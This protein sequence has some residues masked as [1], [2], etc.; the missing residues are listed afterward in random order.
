MAVL[1][2]DVRTESFNKPPPP[3]KKWIQDYLEKDCKREAEKS[4]SRQNLGGVVQDVIDH[5]QDYMDESN[6]RLG[7]STVQLGIGR[8]EQEKSNHFNQLLDPAMYGDK[9]NRSLEKLQQTSL[10]QSPVPNLSRQEIGGVV[11]GVINQF[12]NGNLPESGFRKS[13]K[14]CNRHLNNHREKGKDRRSSNV[15]I[16][17][18][19]LAKMP[20]LLPIYPVI[21]EPL[22]D[23]S[24]VL[25]LSLPKTGSKVTFATEDRCYSEDSMRSSKTSKSQE[26]QDMEILVHAGQIIKPSSGIQT[27]LGHNVFPP[28]LL[29]AGARPTSYSG[30]DVSSVIPPLFVQPKPLFVSSGLGSVINFAKGKEKDGSLTSKPYNV[31]KPV[32]LERLIASEVSSQDTTLVPRTSST[33]CLS[34]KKKIHAYKT[35]NPFHQPSP[36]KIMISPKKSIKDLK[37]APRPQPGRSKPKDEQKKSATSSREMHNRLEK[38]RR[39]LLK[40]CFDELAVECELDPKKSSNLTVIRAAYKYVLGLRRKEKENEKELANLV[41]EKIRKQQ[42]LEELKRTNPGVLEEAI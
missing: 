32:P 34:G 1:V 9:F 15:N 3:K 35:S 2:A 38:N 13:R 14:R 5:F 24:G 8:T 41:K 27:S 25:N 6:R 33:K 36:S 18:E 11:K 4:L 16:E 26:M 42:E 21:S 12:L 10:E 29:S 19:L 20:R 31:I 37:L 28:V 7:S 30:S 17:E 39:A 23:E 22:P 40:K